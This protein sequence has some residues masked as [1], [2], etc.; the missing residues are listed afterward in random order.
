MLLPSRFPLQ[1]LPIPP[2][3]HFYA[4]ALPPTHPILPYHPSIPLCWGI[5]PSQDQGPSLSL[6]PDKAMLC[7]ILQ[8]EPRVPPCAFFG[9][10]FSPWELWGS[11]TVRYC[12]SSYGV[13][14]PFTSF[15]PSSN[16]SIGVPVLSPVVDCAHLYLPGSGR[17]SQETAISC[18]CQQALFGI[19]SSD[20][21]WWLRMGWLPRW[22]SLWMAFPFIFAPLFVPIFP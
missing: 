2:T 10:S 13:A 3:P 9:W 12:C 17:A 18:S 11:L 1:K 14:N 8:L 6:L 20:C 22:D 4:G 21:V 16:S 15:S 5:E 19:S 7:Y